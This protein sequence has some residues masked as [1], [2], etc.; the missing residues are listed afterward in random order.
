M[1]AFLI[2]IPVV[3]LSGTSWPETLRRLQEKWHDIATS[4]TSTFASLTSSSSSSPSQPLGDAPQFQSAKTSSCPSADGKPCPADL[5]LQTP[6]ARRLAGDSATERATVGTVGI[7]AEAGV[8]PASYQTAVG[9]T[10][11]D[12]NAASNPA[13]DRAS[14]PAAHV[15]P[16]AASLPGQPATAADRF[17]YIQSQL[18]RLGATYY[19]LESWGDEQPLYRFYCKMAMG[20]NA[21]YTRYFEATDA[22]PLQA[23]SQVLREVETWR[24]GK[25]AEAVPIAGQ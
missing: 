6:A 18:R 2:G 10:L 8:V 12:Q 5:G 1:L 9:G 24:S 13:A 19:L 14:T 15:N 20:G 22:N 11:G 21:G 23:M 17:A 7:P 3:A 25:N 16:D 4:A